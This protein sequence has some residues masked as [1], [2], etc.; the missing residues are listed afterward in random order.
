MQF[1]RN[2]RFALAGSVR[3]ALTEML[4]AVDTEILPS[5]R[6]AKNK[7]SHHDARCFVTS[8]RPNGAASVDVFALE[9][10][11]RIPVPW[12]DRYPLRSC[13]RFIRVTLC[14]CAS[15]HRNTLLI[16]TYEMTKTR[17]KVFHDVV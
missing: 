9:S 2:A 11:H 4:I 3:R 17:A 10:K 13:D 5:G 12:P 16:N 14:I 8:M 1:R 15:R 6:P 7:R